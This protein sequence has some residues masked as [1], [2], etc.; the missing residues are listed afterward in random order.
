MDGSVHSLSGFLLWARHGFM[1]TDTGK[2]GYSVPAVWAASG[3]EM[4]GNTMLP[5][6]IS[7]DFGRFWNQSAE[8]NSIF[9]ETV[10]VH[11]CV[12]DDL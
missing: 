1:A 11:V 12:R 4:L 5:E 3:G 2:E 10:H 6:T 9:G 8:S 7:N